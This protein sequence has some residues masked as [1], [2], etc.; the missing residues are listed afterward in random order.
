[1]KATFSAADDCD[2]DD[3]LENQIQLGDTDV[4]G[5]GFGLLLPDAES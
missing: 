3:I 2:D 1:M 5:D 4:D